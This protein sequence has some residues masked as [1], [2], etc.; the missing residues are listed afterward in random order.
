MAGYQVFVD[1]AAPFLYQSSDRDHKFIAQGPGL[2]ISFRAD[3][4]F[5]KQQLDQSG[6]IPQV[7]KDQAPEVAALVDPSHQGDQFPHLC[8]YYFRT[9]VASVKAT[10]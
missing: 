7:H 1:S 4:L 9:S 2:L 8:I 5:I 3:G 10:H 6:T